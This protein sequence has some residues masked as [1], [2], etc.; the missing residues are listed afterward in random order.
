MEIPT[1]FKQLFEKDWRECACYGGR[2]SLKSHTVARY[3]LIRA[4]T[5]KTRILC[6]REIQRSIKD[7][8]HQLLADLID[9]YELT[10]FKV[11]DNSILN[12]ING[13]EFI[14]T[15]LYRNEQS[16]KSTEGVDICWVEEA[17]TVTEKSLEVL[18]PTIRKEGSQIIYTYNRLEEED[19]VHKRLVIEGRPKTLILN[20]NYDV[21]LKYD[22]MPDV[23]KAE[24]EDDK[25][26]R[27]ELYRHKWLGEPLTMSEARI[28]SGWQIIDE[29]PHEARLERYGLDFAWKPDMT[30][31]V[32]IYFYHGGYILDEINVQLEWPTTDIASTLRS[33][34]HALC[35]GDSSD[36][37]SINDIR[38]YGVNITPCKKYADSQRHG[39][40]IMQDQRI[41][42]TRH[43]QNIINGYKTWTWKLDKDDKIIPGIAEHEPDSLAAA[44]YA[45]ESLIPIQRKKEMIA[46]LP[47]IHRTRSNIAV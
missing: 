18:T 28:Y 20:L 43:S 1:E 10:D 39:I 46:Q 32:A 27:F 36:E 26:H 25:A 42:V 7:S 37:R 33:L 40:K 21:A 6:C 38:A 35:I 19:P 24:M 5:E 30:A 17:Q 3:L 22:W 13:S 4:R 44:R 16:V 47:R 12:T 2:F 29:I 23:I 41:S 45:I 15:G 11:T 8:S 9:E 34:P 31:L 14:F